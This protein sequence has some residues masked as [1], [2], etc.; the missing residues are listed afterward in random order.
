MGSVTL[1]G[2][3]RREG[4]RFVSR[5]HELDIFTFGDSLEEAV[6]ATADMIDSHF[7]AL[8]KLGLIEETLTKLSGRFIDRAKFEV[9]LSPLTHAAIIDIPLS[10]TA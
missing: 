7:A 3:I 1:T 5:C 2:T 4:T 9:F 8:Q 6:I 10:R